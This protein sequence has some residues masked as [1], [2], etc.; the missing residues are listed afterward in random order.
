MSPE[1]KAELSAKNDAAIARMAA[2]REIRALRKAHKK[3]PQELRVR[4]GFPT[5]E[6]VVPAK[7][8]LERALAQ[9]KGEVAAARTMAGGTAKARQALAKELKIKN[10][11]WMSLVE[12]DDAIS[13]AQEV[14]RHGT[15]ETAAGIRLAA[16]EVKG[17]ERC[18][19]AWA[20]WKAKQEAAR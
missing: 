9:Q 3:V 4:A 13:C 14:Q 15:D 5:L 11:R 19:A 12:L 18:Q 6:A 17:R 10:R 8:K 1:A 20:A 16:L 2:R 7:K